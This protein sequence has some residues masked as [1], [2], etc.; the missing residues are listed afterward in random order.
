MSQLPPRGPTIN[1]FC[2]DGDHSQTSGTA[3]QGHA[4]DVFCVDGGC[5]WT[6]GTAFQEACR[7][8]F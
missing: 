7:R 8:R 5:F 2:V 4:V 3:S 1:V 6:F